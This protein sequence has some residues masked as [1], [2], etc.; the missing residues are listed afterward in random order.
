[1]RASDNELQAM[2]NLITDQ[3]FQVFMGFLDSWLI[4]ETKECINVKEPAVNQGRAQVLTEIKETVEKAR[5]NVT[6]R[7][8]RRAVLS[9]PR[10]NAF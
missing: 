3:N 2:S 4:D 6:K 1:M 9:V 10:A 7:I 8:S 5:E